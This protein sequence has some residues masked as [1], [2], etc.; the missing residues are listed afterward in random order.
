MTAIMR[1][2]RLPVLVAGMGNVLRRD[3]G[4]GVA[5]A[6]ALS[7]RALPSGVTVVDVGIGGIHLVQE[8][9]RGYDALVI[10]DAVDRGAPPGSLFVLEPEIPDVERLSAEERRELLTDMHSA[11]PTRVLLLAKA[12][13]VLPPKVWIVGCQPA[14]VEEFGTEMSQPVR[15]AAEWAVREIEGIVRRLCG[16]TEA[17]E[18]LH[19]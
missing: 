8:L 9:L 13:G 10:V 7:G 18:A 4:F 6:N 12:L 16:T 2:A 15:V 11:V 17:T 1:N 19:G 3:D 14:D 5:V